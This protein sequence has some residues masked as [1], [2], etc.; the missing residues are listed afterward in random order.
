MKCAIG[1]AYLANAAP[2]L[3]LS[4]KRLLHRTPMIGD[5]LRELCFG[6]RGKLQPVPAY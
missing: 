3:K 1:H 2:G 4:D 5:S 6:N